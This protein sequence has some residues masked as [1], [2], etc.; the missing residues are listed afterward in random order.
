MAQ[1]KINTDWTMMEGL[2]GPTDEPPP[3][4]RHSGLDLQAR[5]DRAD[6]NIQDHGL[7]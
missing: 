3:P 1:S 2:Q 5:A 7:G 6:R 4:Q